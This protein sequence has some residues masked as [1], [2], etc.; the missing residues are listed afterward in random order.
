MKKQRLEEE[1]SS[2]GRIYYYNPKTGESTWK[3]PVLA[4]KPDSFFWK[5]CKDQN[6]YFFYY[7]S[8][9][10]ESSWTRPAEYTAK[11]E[12]DQETLFRRQNFFKMM[13]SSVQKDLNP[14]EYNSPAI[15][16]IKE[17]SVRFD[18]DPR[19]INVTEKQRERFFDEW[20]TLERKRRVELEKKMVIHA[21]ERLKEKMFEKV[22]AGIFTIHTKWEDI[23]DKFRYNPDWRILLNYDR[24]QVFI[25]VKKELHDEYVLT[26][27]EKREQQAKEETKRRFN[28]LNA[29]RRFLD[30]YP[31]I[32]ITEITFNRFATEIRQLPEYIDMKKNVNGS[33][34]VDLFYDVVEEK[35]S[36]LDQK[37]EQIHITEEDF[38]FEKF[39]EKFSAIL[40][41][42]KDNEIRYIFESSIRDFLIHRDY[43]TAEAQAKEN[44]LM[45]A[46][47]LN[48]S[49]VTCTSF[50]EA[51]R[52]LSNTRELNDIETE[53]EQRKIFNDFVEWGKNRNCE[54][55]EILP[56]DDDWDDIGPM[57]ENEIRKRQLDQLK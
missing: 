51:K 47:K 16:T 35:M 4:D 6:G 48:A 7:N 27:N 17:A 36:I 29:V 10:K 50:E 44:A 54:P 45:R 15:F 13:S 28:F 18:T 25:E 52:I 56:G 12:H 42:L 8:R 49:L 55:G 9:T 1:L 21:K 14:I 41:D 5:K 11:I 43:L 30:K 34:A 22:E 39:S 53:E 3:N 57:V 2:D 20:L 46:L 31:E 32:P 38:E 26:F 24:L 40:E 33:T 23:I 19:L 37:V